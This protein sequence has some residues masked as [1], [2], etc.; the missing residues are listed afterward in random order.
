MEEGIWV[1]QDGKKYGPY[2][3]VDI[4][5]WQ[6]EGRFSGDAVA[7]RKGMP[8]WI[9][10]ATL[11]GVPA[12]QA[13]PPPIAP[14]PMAAPPPAW[15]PTAA[16]DPAAAMADALAARR[17]GQEEGRDDRSSLPPPPSLHWGLVLLF[18][19]LTLGVFGIV[20]PFI[21]ASWVR[22]IDRQSTAMLL[23]GVA[24]GCDVLGYALILGGAALAGSGGGSSG[25]A[26]LG[27]LLLLAYPVLFIVGY[28]SM[29]ESI[30]HRLARYQVP[31]EIGGVTLFF[32]NVWYMQAQLSWVAR[33]QR[34]G[35]TQPQAT[36]GAFWALFLAFPFVIGILAAI[37]IPA[38]QEYVMRSQVV[39]VL[40][41][42]DALKVQIAEAVSSNRTWPAS[43]AQAGL[44]EPD[45]YA[46]GNLAGFAVQAVE[47]GTTLVASFSDHAPMALRSKRL[48]LVAHAQGGAIVW[49]CESPDIS[50]RYL[51]VQCR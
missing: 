34:T 16:H 43:N 21:Q 48:T 10:L 22:K 20:W 7:W 4:R 50:Q 17:R 42:A 28:F 32:F 6:A 45:E 25:L 5:R 41:Q 29:A 51:P 24:L 13:A 2:S 47:D 27:L 26:G 8:D 49:R 15:S 30:R 46:N 35:Q 18:T 19:I 37:A 44:R 36:K 39:S 31:V 3:E 33:W 9:P 14:P 1:G 12:G 11:L 40:S 23:L 38:Y